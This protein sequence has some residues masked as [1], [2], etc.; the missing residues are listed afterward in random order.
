MVVS[1]LPEK[2]GDG[3]RSTL[4]IEGIPFDTAT[5]EELNHA[6][7][8]LHQAISVLGEMFVSSPF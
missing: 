6:R 2:L 3:F 1:D 5:H 7:H 4:V 8:V